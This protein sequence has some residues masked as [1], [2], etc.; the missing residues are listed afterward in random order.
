MSEENNG[1]GEQTPE[2]VERL[3]KTLAEYD[4]IEKIEKELPE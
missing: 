4:Y 1:F 2:G 3:R